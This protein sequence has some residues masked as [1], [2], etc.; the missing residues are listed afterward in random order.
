MSPSGRQRHRLQAVPTS[1]DSR[2]QKAPWTPGHA[3]GSPELQAALTVLTDGLIEQIADRI[4]GRILAAIADYAEPT[5]PWLDVSG[6]CAYT[7]LSKGALCKLT[8]AGAI[9][10]RKRTGGQGLRFHRA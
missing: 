4:A 2:R 1:P 9:P 6:A 3:D 5:S 10:F 8:A 7:G